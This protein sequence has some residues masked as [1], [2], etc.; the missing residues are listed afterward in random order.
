ML[1]LYLAL[2]LA[3]SLYFKEKL[4]LDVVLLA[5]LYTHR[6]LAGAV[7]AHVAV[8]HWLLGF[9]LFF[10]LSLA[11]VKRY[12]EVQ[13]VAEASSAQLPRRAIQ[14]PDKGVDVAD[15]VARGRAP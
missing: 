12:S 2:T 11:F 15:A 5:A 10:F 4:V 7:A 8:S 3:Y 14:T 6:V 13:R 1:G 9:S